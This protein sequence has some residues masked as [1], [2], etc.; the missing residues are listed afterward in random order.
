MRKPAPQES[1]FLDEDALGA[2]PDLV[3]AASPVRGEGRANR[4][5]SNISEANITRKNPYK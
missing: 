5:Q 4:K 1:I 2:Y 3:V